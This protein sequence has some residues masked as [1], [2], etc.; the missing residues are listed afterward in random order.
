MIII[1]KDIMIKAFEDDVTVNDHI[2]FEEMGELTQAISKFRRKKGCSEDIIKEMAHV[3]Y[4]LKKLAYGFKIT[5]DEINKEIIK[6]ENEILA[7]IYKKEGFDKIRMYFSNDIEEIN[8]LCSRLTDIC[9]E[10]HPC[11]CVDD[12]IVTDHDL[13]ML[14]AI[15]KLE[16]TAT[17]QGHRIIINID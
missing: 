8:D 4:C 5:D 13:S 16:D 6:K 14:K 11:C 9:K 7:E 1:N 3:Y 2:L 15:K 17:Q 12:S 10:E